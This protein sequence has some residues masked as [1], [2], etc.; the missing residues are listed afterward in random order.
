MWYIDVLLPWMLTVNIQAILE[1]TGQ[2]LKAVY[3][4]YTDNEGHSPT[5]PCACFFRLLLHWRRLKVHCHPVTVLDY[6]IRM[7][8]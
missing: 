8:V 6:D 4:P 2:R 1:S 5:G 3:S 7:S